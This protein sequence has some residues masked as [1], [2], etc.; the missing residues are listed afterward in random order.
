MLQCLYQLQQIIVHHFFDSLLND[1]NLITQAEMVKALFI[2]FI[3]FFFF[4]FFLQIRNSTQVLLH[5]HFWYKPFLHFFF[6][7]IFLIRSRRFIR[8]LFHS[9]LALW[10]FSSAKSCLLRYSVPWSGSLLKTN[11]VPLKTS[12]F[13]T[14]PRIVYN[15]DAIY[16]NSIKNEKQ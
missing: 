15:T 9:Y 11:L 6:F 2:I 3:F 12:A 13:T 4:F 1:K 8:S 16:F 5:Q 14:A 7:F 10:S